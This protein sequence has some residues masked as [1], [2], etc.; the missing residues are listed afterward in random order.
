MQID[1]GFGS[2]FDSLASFIQVFMD[3]Y[4]MKLDV[5]N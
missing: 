4:D 3:E 1:A 5:T 2:I